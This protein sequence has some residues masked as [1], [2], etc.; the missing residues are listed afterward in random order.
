MRSASRPAS[1]ISPLR[2]QILN[3]S[4]SKPTPSPP[5]EPQIVPP[6]ANAFRGEKWRPEPPR[7]STDST[8]CIRS[9]FGRKD[10]APIIHFPNHTI[11]KIQAAPARVQDCPTFQT[12]KVILPLSRCRGSNSMDLSSPLDFPSASPDRDRHS[13]F[14]GSMDDVEAEMR[15]L[16]W[17][18]SKQW[19][20]KRTPAVENG[21]GTE[22]EAARLAE[23][24]ALAIAEEEKAKSR[25]AWKRPKR[26]GGLQKLNHKKNFRYRKYT[27]EEIEAATEFFSEALKI[28]E[29]GYGPVYKGHLDH[30]PV[31]IKVLR[32]D[33][34]QGRGFKLHTA[35]QYGLL[36]GACPEYG[37]LVYE[38]MAYGSLEDRL[39]RRGNTPTLSW[40]I[41]FRIAA[42][43]GTALLLVP[44]SV[45]ESVTQYRMT[46]TAGTF[47]YID[48]EY[49]QTG[50]LG[51]KS[52]VY[53]FGIMLLQIIS[54]KP[55]MGLAHHMQRAIEKGTFLQMLDPTIHDGRFKRP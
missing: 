17:S 32:P 44:P 19:K 38:F 51:V 30:T 49:Q 31:A 11:T 33:A 26:L 35:S 54:A 21:R 16:S 52:D 23:E 13:N 43:I 36:L 5:P 42:E 25:A 45:A 4:K 48:P 1:A 47:C 34:A 2:N 7:Q 24:A 20:C 40:Q 15:R 10:R 6:A 27:I 55:P 8:D 41:R 12:M 53:S 50:M 3:Q 37:C 28:G 22:M 14:S 9:P 29:G 39:F 18:S 46:A